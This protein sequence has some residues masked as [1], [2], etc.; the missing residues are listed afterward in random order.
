MQLTFTIDTLEQACKQIWEAGKAYKTWAFYGD[1]G[2][3]KTT[4]I[5]KLCEILGVTST[6][7]SPTYPIIN[8]YESRV[9]GVIYH[10]DWYRI[11]SEQEA[12]EAGIE[13]C[14]YSG[15]YCFIEWPQKAETLL[16]EKIFKLTLSLI[17]FNTRKIEIEA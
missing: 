1:M 17:D 9:A 3:G 16:P 8:E 15:N 7:S 6:I 10:M 5:H 12:I 11:K 13:D 14:M 4:F 2:A